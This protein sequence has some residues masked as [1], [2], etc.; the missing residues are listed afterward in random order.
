M[1]PAPE[2]SAALTVHEEALIAYWEAIEA[3]QAE[4][5]QALREQDPELDDFLAREAQLDRLFAPFRPALP[6][7]ALPPGTRIND[8]EILE[9][10]DRGGMG[11]VYR[12]LQRGPNREVALKM[13]RWGKGLRPRKSTG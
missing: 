3:G 12:A 8:Y 13:L 6:P 5:G 4:K 2:T 1:T 9:Y 10:L 11:V 7:P